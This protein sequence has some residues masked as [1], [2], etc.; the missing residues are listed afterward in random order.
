VKI[1]GSGSQRLECLVRYCA[2]PP[3]SDERLDRLNTESLVHNLRK[4]ALDSRTD[5][6]LTRLELLDRLSQLITP[7]RLHK[8]RYGGV[9]G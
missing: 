6:L 9:C 3:L 4:P 7:P 8:H 2:R 1:K 5:L